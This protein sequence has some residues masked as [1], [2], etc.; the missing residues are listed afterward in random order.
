MTR[1]GKDRETYTMLQHF[2]LRHLPALFFACAHCMG[3][4]AGP[5]RGTVHVMEMYGFGPAITGVPEAQVAWEA[6]HGRT[7]ALGLLMLGFY[8]R[9]MYAACDGVLVAAAWLGVN[10]FL[11]FRAQG[12]LAWASFRLLGSLSFAVMGLFGITQGLRPER[13][14][15]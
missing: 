15:N 6:G 7:V 9:R 5:L 2:S 12:D 8:A 14:T 13:R 10:D 4:V 11:V 3:L 1:T